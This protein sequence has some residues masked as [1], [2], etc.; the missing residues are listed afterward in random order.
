MKKVYIILGIIIVYAIVGI[1]L[2]RDT[3]DTEVAFA[4]TFI[5]ETKWVC[6]KTLDGSYHYGEVIVYDNDEEVYRYQ[7]HYQNSLYRDI[8]FDHNMIYLMGYQFTKDNIIDNVFITSISTDYEVVDNIQFSIQ[9]EIYPTNILADNDSVYILGSFTG[10]NFAGIELE[11]KGEYDIFILELN[12]DLEME[13]IYTYG[14][15]LSDLLSDSYI[16]D[17]SIII[18]YNEFD[19]LVEGNIT[20]SNLGYILAFDLIT[21]DF[22]SLDVKIQSDKFRIQ[23][24]IK[25]SNSIGYFGNYLDS[26]TQLMT[27]FLC[28]GDYCTTFTDFEVNGNIVDGVKTDSGYVLLL[29]FEHAGFS[30]VYG[31]ISRKM[32]LSIEDEI[33]DLSALNQDI[34]IQE[35]TF[36]SNEVYAL[37]YQIDRYFLK[38]DR[39]KYYDEKLYESNDN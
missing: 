25:D 1:F 39:T 15:L 30:E 9:G 23:G 3:V 38:A 2:F 29:A 20:E 6:G 18:S 33:L 36:Y 7:T 21:R 32:I 10:S 26:Q 12:E 37:G 28:E 8:I 19:S 27:P 14:Q 4:Q 35:L 34:Y 24:L 5:D 13:N 17:S 22:E 11:S 31:D 16:K